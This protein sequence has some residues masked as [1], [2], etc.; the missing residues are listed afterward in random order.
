MSD[1]A[2]EWKTAHEELKKAVRRRGGWETALPLALELHAETHF[3]EM[4]GASVPTWADEAWE[5]LEGPLFAAAAGSK[6][7]TAAWNLWHIARIEDL[8]ANLLIAES[9]QVLYGEWMERIGASVTDTGNAMSRAEI[10]EFSR[11]IRPDELKN[12]DNAVGRRTREVLQSLDPAEIS[13]KPRPEALERIMTEGGLTEQEGSFWL[14]DFW[15]GKTVG[16]LVLLPLTRHRPMHLKDCFRLKE[17]LL[18]TGNS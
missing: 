3:A 4:S 6:G 5:G 10:A 17:K 13:R 12:Y 14:K 16:G 15:G 1:K 11:K 9:T 2:L 8:I 7:A 18:K